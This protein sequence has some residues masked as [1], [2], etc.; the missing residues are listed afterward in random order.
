MLPPSVVLFGWRSQ[1]LESRVSLR[2][3]EDGCNVLNGR[4]DTELE[5]TFDGR[6]LLDAEHLEKVNR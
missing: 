3:T 1:R 2:N 6:E 5:K 4:D